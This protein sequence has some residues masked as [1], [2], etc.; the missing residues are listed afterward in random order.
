MAWKFAR[1]ILV[2]RYIKDTFIYLLMVILLSI[3]A[4]FMVL[5]SC[6]SVRKSLATRYVDTMFELIDAKKG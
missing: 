4:L 3:T 6:F 5:A 2:G 1:I